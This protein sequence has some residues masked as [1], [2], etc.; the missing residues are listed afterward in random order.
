VESGRRCADFRSLTIQF[1]KHLLQKALLDQL[2]PEA[3]QHRVIRRRILKAQ[4]DE[5]LERQARERRP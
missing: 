3:V 5:A 4:T 2:V 1:A